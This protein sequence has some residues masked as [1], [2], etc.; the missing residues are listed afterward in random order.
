M[1][2]RPKN[3]YWVPYVFL[4]TPAKAAEFGLV[5]GQMYE[6]MQVHILKKVGD[7]IEDGDV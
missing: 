5:E 7:Q 2:V 1:E 4:C 6:G 3:S